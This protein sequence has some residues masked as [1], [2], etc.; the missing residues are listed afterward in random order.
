MRVATLGAL[1]NALPPSDYRMLHY[2][3][4]TSE[5]M[6]PYERVSVLGGLGA[7]NPSSPDFLWGAFAGMVVGIGLMGL[8]SMVRR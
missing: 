8:V 5:P 3:Y 1:P 2:G 6:V 7:V 4:A